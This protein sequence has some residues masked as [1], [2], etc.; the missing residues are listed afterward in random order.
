MEMEIPSESPWG[1]QPSWLET[2]LFEFELAWIRNE[3]PRIEA[4]LE[5]VEAGK[6][7]ELLRELL[8][9]EWLWRYRSNKPPE[10]SEYEARFPANTA[11]LRDAWEYHT[12]LSF[13]GSE[14]TH[15]FPLDQPAA[16]PRTQSTEYE[17]LPPLESIG[18]FRIL[19]KLGSGGF[20]WFRRGISGLG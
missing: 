12:Q 11:A 19:R 13:L 6:R 18:R 2:M 9:A 4:F 20:G 7:E 5:R 10:L 8:L 14:A 3:S 16:Q 15:W 17:S 1:D